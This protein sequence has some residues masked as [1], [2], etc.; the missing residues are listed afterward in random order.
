VVLGGGEGEDS[1]ALA[2]LSLTLLHPDGW[3]RTNF[4]VY[5]RFGTTRTET[6]PLDC[7]LS[8]VCDESLSK[9]LLPMRSARTNKT[10]K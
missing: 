10:K 6:R 1:V 9:T 2:T 3:W 8:L 5:Q 7:R 4:D